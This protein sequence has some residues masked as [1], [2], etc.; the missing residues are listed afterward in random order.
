MSLDIY[1]LLKEGDCVKIQEALKR[2]RKFANERDQACS[3]RNL[4]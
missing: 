4:A 2:N 1:E 3:V